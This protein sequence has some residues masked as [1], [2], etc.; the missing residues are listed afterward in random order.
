ML[1]CNLMT[2]PYEGAELAV[3]D[4]DSLFCG[5]VSPATDLQVESFL[6]HV[7]V[8]HIHGVFFHCFL[9]VED[10]IPGLL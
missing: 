7:Y 1:Y 5:G 9:V 2:F 3:G 8:V 4:P 10:L 6:L